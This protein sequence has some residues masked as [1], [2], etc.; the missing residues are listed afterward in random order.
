MNILF[1]CTGN[2]CRSPMAEVILQNLAPNF[3]V[4]SA[5][6]Y[7][8]EGQDMNPQAQ[9]VLL[10]HQLASTHQSK[11]V[12][13]DL[14]AWADYVFTMTA[15]HKVMLEISFPEATEK[16]FTLK[17]F[18]K[19]DQDMSVDVVDPFGQSLDVY[20]ATFAEL[21]SLIEKACQKIIQNL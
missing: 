18:V 21:T 16:V 1:V 3:N 4:Q 13:V 7:A 9:E 11:Q 6:I 5:G 20:A 2:T 8:S 19:K 15:T 10:N 12:T 17:E 14:M